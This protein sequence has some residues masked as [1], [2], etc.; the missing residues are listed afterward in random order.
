MKRSLQ[1]LFIVLI[2]FSAACQS[3]GKVVEK[4]VAGDP[5]E[6]HKEPKKF[7]PIVYA[8]VN[9][10]G[11]DR[12]SDVPYYRSTGIGLGVYYNQPLNWQ[13]YGHKFLYYYADLEFQP[14]KVFDE[15]YPGETNWVLASSPGIRYRTYLPVLFKMYYGGGV[16]L[17]FTHTNYDPWGVYLTT[18]VQ[19]YGLTA[20]TKFIGHPGQSNWERE[21]Q[22]GWMYAPVN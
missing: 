12:R 14:E 18:G 4:P 16:D 15:S 1:I 3:P 22:F 10:R 9:D 21:Y 20:G 7:L 2:L 19:L 6:F 8:S 11:V 17:K 5:T 13:W